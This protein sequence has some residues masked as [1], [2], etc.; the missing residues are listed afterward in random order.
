MADTLLYVKS[1][2]GFQYEISSDDRDICHLA[3]C[4]VQSPKGKTLWSNG[5]KTVFE[6]TIRRAT[7]FQHKHKI[8][9]VQQRFSYQKDTEKLVESGSAERTPQ[10]DTQYMF[11]QGR[12][13]ICR[14]TDP[15][16]ADPWPLLRSVS[17]SEQ[18]FSDGVL[19][20]PCLSRNFSCLR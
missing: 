13:G 11:S 5:G 17:C 20:Y 9:S 10:R 12:D 15:T 7:A 2:P 1:L 14:S 4:S 19:I 16:K 18:S 3:F 8:T 6:E